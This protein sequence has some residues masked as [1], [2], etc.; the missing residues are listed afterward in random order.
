MPAPLFVV[1]RKR[2]SRKQGREKRPGQ[3]DRF[4]SDESEVPIAEWV[5]LKCILGLHFGARQQ[6]DL[7]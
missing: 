7:T 2:S 3:Q 6:K 5:S 4:R 1:S